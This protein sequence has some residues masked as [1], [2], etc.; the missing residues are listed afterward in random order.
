[1]RPLFEKAGECRRE[2]EEVGGGCQRYRQEERVESLKCMV[3]RLL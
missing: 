2:E 3:S 1:M